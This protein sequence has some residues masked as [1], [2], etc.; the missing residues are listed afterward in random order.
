MSFE[1]SRRLLGT[2]VVYASISLL[3]GTISARDFDLSTATIKDIN[4]AMDA[5]KLSSEQLVRL[6]LNRIAAY[7]QQGPK[8][9]ALI[10]V[11]PEALAIARALDEERKTKGRRS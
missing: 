3:A 10:T 5:G 2:L 1:R 7:D 8:L 4:D 11:N 9:N 6:Y